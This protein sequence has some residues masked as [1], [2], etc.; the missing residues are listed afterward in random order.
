MAT[1]IPMDEFVAH[2][3]AGNHLRQG[4]FHPKKLQEFLLFSPKTYP[5]ILLI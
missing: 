4:E 2:G 3:D 5:L 1:S